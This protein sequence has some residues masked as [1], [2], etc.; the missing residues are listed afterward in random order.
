MQGRVR[1]HLPY[2]GGM[3]DTLADQTRAR[4]AVFIGAALLLSLMLGRRL[5]R[6]VAAREIGATRRGDSLPARTG[7]GH[8]GRRPDPR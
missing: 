6:T 4:Y 2:V 1:Y 7:I 3:I 8:T 5:R